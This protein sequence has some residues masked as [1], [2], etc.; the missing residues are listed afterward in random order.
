MYFSINRN[1][2]LSQFTRSLNYVFLKFRNL[3]RKINDA[4]LKLDNMLKLID[5]IENVY[6]ETLDKFYFHKVKAG[7]HFS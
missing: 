3:T 2:R 6:N 1:F 4:I 5:L 7:K